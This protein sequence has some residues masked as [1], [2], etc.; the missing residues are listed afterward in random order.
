MDENRPSEGSDG[1]R[2]VNILLI[3]E[4]MCRRLDGIVGKASR[5][6]ERRMT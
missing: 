6:A 2:T 5:E 3:S 1:H 4:A